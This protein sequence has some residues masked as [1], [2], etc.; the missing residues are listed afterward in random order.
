MADKPTIGI[1]GGGAVGLAYVYFL[2]D[3]AD[4]IIKTRSQSQADS[5]NSNGVQ[6]TRG[7][8]TKDIK[9]VRASSDMSDFKDCAAVIVAVKSY[10]T[11]DIAN[12]LSQ[13]IQLN[14]QVISVQ[15]GLQAVDI[16][17]AKLPNPERVFAGVTYIGARRSDERSFSLGQSNRTVVD[18][19]ATV[20]IDALQATPFGVET[21]DN[22][23]QAVWDKLVL[24]VGQNALSAITNLSVQQMLRSEYCLE[25]ASKIL[26]EF[27]QVAEAEGLNFAY[28]LMEK[29]K[30]NWAGGDDF[31]PSMWQDLHHG[32]RTEID[33]LNGAISELGKKHG[34]DTPYNSMTTLV[35][36]ALET[37][38]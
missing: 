32:R 4:V 6:I 17:K 8:E 13:V 35:V 7:G 25:I 33:A 36:K 20:L 24:N 29:L 1:I 11:K 38:S 30:G 10:H 14:T 19:A 37:S 23:K 9:N 2:A 34:I 3:V 31:Y 15:N 18:P 26:N 22:I 16:L 21:P 12:E 5:I 27:Q 28:S